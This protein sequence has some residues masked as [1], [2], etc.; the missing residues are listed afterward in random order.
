[1]LIYVSPKPTN[2]AWFPLFYWGGFCFHVL[3]FGWSIRKSQTSWTLQLQKV[4]VRITQEQN[5]IIIYNQ[6]TTITPK[7]F[8][9]GLLLPNKQ[10]TYQIPYLL[11]KCSSQLCSLGWAG[12]ESQNQSRIRHCLCQQISLLSFTLEQ[13]LPFPSFMMLTVLKR[14]GHTL[15]ICLIV[16][17]TFWQEHDTGDIVSFPRHHILRRIMSICTT[18]NDVK[19]WSLT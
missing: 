3:F 5:H 16:S 10:S 19:M 14:L 17:H 2:F 12:R 1:M 7:K 4:Q 11:Q 6:C 15:W 9:T 13:S 8:K 18:T